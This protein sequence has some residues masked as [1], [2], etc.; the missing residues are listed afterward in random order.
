M[1]GN[2]R[3]A[4]Q[5]GLSR[6]EGHR[7][8]AEAVRRVVTA[9]RELGIRHLTLYSF[10]RENWSRPRT[11]ITLLFGLLTDFLGRE[12]STLQKHDIRLGLFGEIADLPL[13]A[14][15][16][17]EHVLDKTRDNGSMRL[18]LALNYSGREEIILACRKY[19]ENGGRPEELTPEALS[20]NLYSAGQPDPDLI[21]RTSGEYR[22]SNF[23]LFQSAYS[24]YH[25]TETLWPDFEKNHLLEALRSYSG[26][27][28]R[29]G[30][31]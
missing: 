1:D 18:N 10:S 3:W 13:P 27:V 12:L 24:E 29:F 26:R 25:F 9:A 5:R 19:L 21:I 6:G 23:L 16:A 20:S 7:A 15:K 2:G 4:E 8:G 11:E 14:R 17:L 30:N 22:V 28:R 31:I